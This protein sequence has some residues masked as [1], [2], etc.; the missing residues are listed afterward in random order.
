M[1]PAAPVTTN[2]LP[3]QLAGSWTLADE[4]GS[5]TSK[6]TAGQAQ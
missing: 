1:G 3:G 2:C 6:V 4:D 5:G